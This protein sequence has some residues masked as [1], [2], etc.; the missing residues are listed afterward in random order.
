VRM[1]SYIFV[2][3]VEFSSN[4]DRTPGNL[5]GCGKLLPKADISR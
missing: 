3:P 1:D 4:P 5:G 2:V